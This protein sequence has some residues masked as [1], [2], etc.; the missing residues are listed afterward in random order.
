MV[1]QVFTGR[2]RRSFENESFWGN[3][4]EAFITYLTPNWYTIAILILVCWMP[5]P[6][7]DTDALWRT[8]GLLGASVLTTLL[9][10][11][12]AVIGS[13]ARF[14]SKPLRLFLAGIGA[15]VTIL[16]MPILTIVF[17]A[18]DASVTPAEW[19]MVAC[20]MA[21][22]FVFGAFIFIMHTAV[23]RVEEYTGEQ[24]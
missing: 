14:S 2:G 11:I 10:G 15:V 7:S 5:D 21:F 13:E 20:G 9:F 18:N 1:E 3:V 24:R 8:V 6:A 17:Q 12:G 16:F 22:G 23:R 19:L 4:G